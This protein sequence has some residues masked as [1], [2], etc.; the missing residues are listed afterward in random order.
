[1]SRPAHTA[2]CDSA[3]LGTVT[4]FLPRLRE[5]A[6]RLLNA[7]EP[8]D[9]VTGCQT[10][11]SKYSPVVRITRNDEDQVRGLEGAPK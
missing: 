6:R 5:S 9:S 8:F 11:L 1:M 10:T 2:V 4:E 7:N 3:T